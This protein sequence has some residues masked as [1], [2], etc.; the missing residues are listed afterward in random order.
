MDLPITPILCHALEPHLG[1]T[2]T[3]E[4]AARIVAA[5]AMACY[6]GPIDIS[7]VEPLETGSYLI[8]CARVA[9][10]M[11]RLRTLHEQHWIET[12]GYH[13]VAGFNPDY[14]RGY[15]LEAQGRY[16]LIVAEDKTTGE[17]VGNY[18]L[19]VSRS[20]HTQQLVATEDTLFVSRPHRRGRLGIA[21][22]RYGEKTLTQLGCVEMSVDVK[23]S[24]N[25]GQMINRM[26]YEPVGTKY[27]K[28]LKEVANVL[29]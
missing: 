6:P 20:M 22:I 4:V 24:N 3:P 29:P 25:V 18:G 15:D 27:T 1:C 5:A 26:G 2:L 8:K 28:I 21:L 19:Y 9:D 17:V 12:E 13:D 23:L 16:L 14:Q 10:Y 7:E 11:G